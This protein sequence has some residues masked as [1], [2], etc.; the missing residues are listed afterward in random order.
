MNGQQPMSFG[1]PKPGPA[2]WSILGV[3]A[4][5]GIVGA[6]LATWIPALERV[7][8]LLACQVDGA[9]ERP[10]LPFTQPWRL[11]TS[12]LLTNPAQWSHLLFS[13]AG[14]YFLGVPLERRWGPWRLVRFFALAIVFGN[15]AAIGAAAVMP[16]DAQSRFHPD[17]VL[18]PTAAITAIAVAW[19]REF[20][21]STV[22]LFFVLPLRGATFLWLTIGLCALDLIY[23]TALPE[24]VI[25]PFGGVV[26]GLLFGGSPSLM[27]TAW[28]RLRLLGLRRRASGMRVDDLLSAKRARRP[29]PGAPPLRIVGGSADEALKKRTPPKDKRYL[30]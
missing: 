24:G 22:N 14:L 7:S 21:D 29:R 12:G 4:A 27:R 17:L 18:G 3:M 5:F 26:A 25:A 1:L 30:N 6:F 10:W 2:L 28:L 19:S 15:L 8:L 9:F 16:A 23:P 20:R 11:V 13:L